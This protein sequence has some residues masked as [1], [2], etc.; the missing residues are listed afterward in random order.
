M[1]ISETSLETESL[2]IGLSHGTKYK[3]VKRLCHEYL[4]RMKH[5]QGARVIN[6]LYHALV[7]LQI[8]WWSALSIGALEESDA[9]HGIEC[10]CV[11]S[12]DAFGLNRVFCNL[13][14][15][16]VAGPDVLYLYYCTL[17]GLEPGVEVR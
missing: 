8:A 14:P 5:L 7:W 6:L 17:S 15:V 10:H 11:Q 4:A 16:C 2:A 13:I 3:R 12:V 1:I 9:V